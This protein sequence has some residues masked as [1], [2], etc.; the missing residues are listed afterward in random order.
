MPNACQNAHQ[1]A[2]EEAARVLGVGAAA[3]ADVVSRAYK[4]LARTR[5]PDKGGTDAAFQQLGQAR[6]VLLGKNTRPDN[7]RAEEV[8]RLHSTLSFECI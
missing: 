7:A 1:S 2:L 3:P 8:G 5:H 4:L 6:D